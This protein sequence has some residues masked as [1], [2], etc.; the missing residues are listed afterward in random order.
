MNVTNESIDLIKIVMNYAAGEGILL[1]TIHREDKAGAMEVKI[2]RESGQTGRARKRN[3]D[4]Q[5]GWGGCC[6]DDACHQVTDAYSKFGVAAKAGTQLPSK[7]RTHDGKKRAN[8]RGKRQ[9]HTY[10]LT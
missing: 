10:L 6:N 7:A 4:V 8:H 5:L 1:A 2:E 9:A 3:R